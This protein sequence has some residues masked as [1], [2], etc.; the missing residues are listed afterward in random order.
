M[1][2]ADLVVTA[3]ESLDFHAVGG[4]IVKRAVSMAGAALRPAIA[5]VGRNFVSAREL[6]L[7]GFEEAYPLG[8]AGE[9]PT[10]ERLSEVAMRVA[11][12][13]SW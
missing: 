13:W 12:T 8:A 7:A 2:A 10:P 11:T 1:G 4:P 9:E 3:A 5:I 6:R